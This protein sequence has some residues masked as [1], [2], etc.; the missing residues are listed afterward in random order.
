MSSTRFKWEPRHSE[1]GVWMCSVIIGANKTK[2]AVG[3]Y[4]DS[5]ASGGS[6]DVYLP[7]VEMDTGLLD[8][9][10]AEAARAGVEDLAA[11]LLS[12]V[13]EWEAEQEAKASG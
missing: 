4:I 8:A 1:Q 9:P 2:K 6:M 11:R 12:V 7:W 10:S 3:G 13:A 5:Y